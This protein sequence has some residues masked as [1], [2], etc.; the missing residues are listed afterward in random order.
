MGKASDTATHLPSG[1]TMNAIEITA[2][3]GPEVLETCRR[4]IPVPG[5]GKVLI[6]VVAA[7]INHA[8]LMQ[9]RGHYPPPKAP[10]IFPDWRW[11]VSL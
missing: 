1:E 9:R 2:P 5:P 4:L 10:P 11:R 6:K 7:G 3:G 8:D